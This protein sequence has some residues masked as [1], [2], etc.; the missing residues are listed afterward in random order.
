MAEVED[1]QYLFK[2]IVI[3][4][5]KAGKTTF[6]IRLI[7][8]EFE[9]S[10]VPTLGVDFSDKTFVV[11]GAAVSTQFWDVGGQDEFRSV[12]KYYYRGAHCSLVICDILDP[13]SWEKALKWKSDLDATV[14]F[15]NSDAPIPAILLFNKCDLP[16]KATDEEL[17]EIAKKGKFDAWYKVSVKDDFG[18]DEAV[19]ELLRRTISMHDEFNDTESEEEDSGFID[20]TGKET[21]PGG[22]GCCGK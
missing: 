17:E 11:D 7:H 12:V 2:L 16:Y 10:Y 22:G 4:P 18:L 5:G 6:I 13:R 14:S 15:S 20:V 9:E 3:G 21:T 8:D 1:P 19:V